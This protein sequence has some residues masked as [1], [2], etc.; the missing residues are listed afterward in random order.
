M[1]ANVPKQTGCEDKLITLKTHTC[2]F[3]RVHTAGTGAGTAQ[4]RR[5]AEALAA[6]LS[7]MVQV[8]AVLA[9]AA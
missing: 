7:R 5:R 1:N 4:T 8:A 2:T 6:Q 9:A 3:T